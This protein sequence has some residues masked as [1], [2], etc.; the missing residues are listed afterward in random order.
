MTRFIRVSLV[1]AVGAFS[2][3]CND[4]PTESVPPVIASATTL[5]TEAVPGWQLADTAKVILLDDAGQP[6][7]GVEVTWSVREG[8]GSVTPV[9]TVTD[10]AG[11]SAA[12]WTLGPVA[13]VNQLRAS[14]ILG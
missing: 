4:Q 1:S 7:S 11:V 12:V 8:G 13:G 2:L 6:V 5:P 9:N 14:T 10:A 3:A